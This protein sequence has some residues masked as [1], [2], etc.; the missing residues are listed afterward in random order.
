M[1]FGLEIRGCLKIFDFSDELD[2]P[3]PL[4][5]GGPESRENEQFIRTLLKVPLPKGDLGGSGIGQKRNYL[6]G[7]SAIVTSRLISKSFR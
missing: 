1:R 6:N 3:N 2:P 5:K 4:G 7:I